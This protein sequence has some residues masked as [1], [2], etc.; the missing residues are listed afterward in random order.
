MSTLKNADKIST[1]E[2]FPAMLANSFDTFNF[3]ENIDDATGDDGFGRVRDIGKKE[4]EIMPHGIKAENDEAAQAGFVLLPITQLSTST[5]NPRTRFAYEPLE[6][7][8]ES[9][10]AHGILEP[11][12][13]RPAKS[14][15]KIEPGRQSSMTGMQDGFF[16]YN[17]D[18]IDS[19]VKSGY[20]GYETGAFPHFIRSATRPQNW[21][22][23]EIVAGERR[24]RAALKAKL[25]A[26][27]CIVKEL[28]DADAIQIAVTENL[29]RSDLSPFEE[30][31][32]FELMLQL[33]EMTQTLVAEKLK[34]PQSRI[35]RTLGL[36]KL[37]EAVRTM[38]EK[39][40]LSA[41]HGTRLLPFADFPDVCIALAQIAVAKE[42]PVS[43]LEGSKI[44]DNIF[45]ELERLKPSPVVALNHWTTF[46][47]KS[48]CAVNCPFRA[49]RPGEYESRGVCLK[50]EHYNELQAEGQKIKDAKLAEANAQAIASYQ[51]RRP[52]LVLPVIAAVPAAVAEILPKPP[53]APILHWDD[54]ATRAAQT[55]VN[56]C[57]R[58]IEIKSAQPAPV[59]L[60]STKDLEHYRLI[61][62][63]P[64]GCSESC[65]CRALATNFHGEVIEICTNVARYDGF[66]KEQKK[67]QEQALRVEAEAR[68]AESFRILD[69]QFP[70][71]PALFA[72]GNEPYPLR[73]VAAIAVWDALFTYGE[74]DDIKLALARRAI[75]I[76]PALFEHDYNLKNQEARLVA[77]LAQYSSATLLGLS[78]EV[79][80]RRE[81]RKSQKFSNANLGLADFLTGQGRSSNG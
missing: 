71:A 39:D 68:L 15:W 60:I 38:I 55:L 44:S 63:P 8:A 7:L 36:L 57:V 26:V 50:P 43:K 72:T 56:A 75:Q 40:E 76:D 30:A 70:I 34:C 17:P 18:L 53:E 52:M 49:Y 81:A 47:W 73:Q 27:P 13:V 4:L 33:P 42:W 79:Q 74:I 67:R 21:P 54:H 65:P 77:E 12:I 66:A 2:R 19:S 41:S 62:A 3:D 80:L 16:L 25:E 78:A 64:Q 11:I 31:R 51:E 58:L 23:F 22:R 45:Y 35:S 9:I 59:E 10:K 14:S 1:L 28:S 69:A 48:V 6:Q 37:P 32:G 61:S 29:Q 20:R 46:D 24:Y 5:F